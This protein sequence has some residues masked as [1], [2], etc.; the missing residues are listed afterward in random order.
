MPN[1]D[2]LIRQNRKK[3]KQHDTLMGFF[4]VLKWLGI[5]VIVLSIIAVAGM[6]IVHKV[7]TDSEIET[8]TKSGFYNQVEVYQN[9]MMNAVKHGNQNSKYAIVPIHDIGDE[10]FNLSIKTMLEPLEK[11]LQYTL[12]NRPGHGFSEDVS[13]DR[14]VSTIVEEYRKALLQ[15]DIEKQVILVSNG[16]G[17]IY[18]KYWASKYPEEVAGVIYIGLENYVDECKVDIKESTAFELLACKL[19]FSRLSDF[20]D[21]RTKSNV[22]DN[23]D[24]EALKYMHIHSANSKAKNAEIATAKQNYEYVFKNCNV[25][26]PQVFVASLGGFETYAEAA[27]YVNFQNKQNESL[28]LEP[29]IE[30]KKNGVTPAVDDFVSESKSILS[31]NKINFVNKSSNCMMTKIPGPAKV[32]RYNPYAVQSLI[33]D[34][35]AYADGT[36]TSVKDIYKDQHAANWEGYNQD[37]EVDKTK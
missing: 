14:N 34:V 2:D 27:K 5:S 16:F 18:A 21:I 26:I 6:A 8:L 33:K 9:Q 28:G 11:D 12:I 30:M 7:Q 4:N 31:N 22:A 3:R 29:M 13:V 37:T 17:G 1:R 32:Y 35:V 24:S 25:N 15:L 20:E 19:G 36:I 10:D 23:D